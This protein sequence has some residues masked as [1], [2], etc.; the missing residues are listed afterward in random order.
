MVIHPCSVMK[1][2]AWSKKSS[3]S[4]KCLLMQRLTTNDSNNGFVVVSEKMLWIKHLWLKMSYWGQ[5]PYLTKINKIQKKGNVNGNTPLFSNKEF[6]L[7]QE[8]FLILK[9]PFNAKVDHKR[10]KQK[11]CC[12]QQKNAMNQTSLTRTVILRPKSVLDRDQ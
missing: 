2:L 6:W 1:N 3:W 7:I 11:L 4:W 9:I 5:S 12:H 8:I 10:I